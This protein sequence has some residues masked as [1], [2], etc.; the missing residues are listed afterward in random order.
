MYLFKKLFSIIIIMTILVAALPSPGVSEEAGELPQ[1]TETPFEEPVQTDEPSPS[2]QATP[3][4]MASPTPETSTGPTAKPTA[5]I[6]AGASFETA[7]S[8]TLDHTMH[9][10]ITQEL[11]GIYFYLTVAQSGDYTF[12]S[13]GDIAIRADLINADC[14]TIALFKPDVSSTESGAPAYFLEMVQLEKSVCY[15]LYVESAVPGKAGG[16]TL[17]A[18]RFVAPQVTAETADSLEPSTS[19]KALSVESTVIP[20]VTQESE[21]MATPVPEETPAPVLAA[22]AAETPGILSTDTPVPTVTS[23]P[24]LSVRVPAGALTSSEDKGERRI[25]DNAKKV[26]SITL[27]PESSHPYA[28]NADEYWYYEEPEATGYTFTFSPDTYTEA[29]YDYIYFYDENMEQIQF[30]DNAGFIIERFTGSQ[31]AG[32]QFTVDCKR[33]YIELRA[34]S[35]VIGY[36]FRFTSIV[37]RYPE[38]DTARIYTCEQN[39]ASSVR[40]TWNKVAQATGYKLYRATSQRGSYSYAGNTTELSATASSLS[41]GRTY[42]FKVRPYRVLGRTTSYWGYS[43]AVPVTVLA[44]PVITKSD[45][46]G[47][48]TA[49]IQWK[50]VPG[51]KGYVLYRANSISGNYTVVAKVDTPYYYNGGL[52]ENTPYYY[53]VAAYRVYSTTVYGALSSA[54]RMVRYRVPAITYVHQSGTTAARIAWASMGATGMKY[55]A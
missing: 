32:K 33:F 16:F 14:N 27:Y 15:Y 39:G 7:I 48:N 52:T 45:I 18:A 43:D 41:A 30:H 55:T 9:S 31:L 25:P 29:G 1:S 44:K 22:V 4:E 37:P 2:P 53:K 36:G 47:A 42:W 19:P 40:V 17:S 51:A 20:A 38:A 23:K 5:A 50:E 24:A 3:E 6:L 21:P 12:A 11:P 34:D 28:N 13:G 54:S 46:S 10:R 8:L 35:E 49:L 26:K